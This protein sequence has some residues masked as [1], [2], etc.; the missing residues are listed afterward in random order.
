MIRRRVGFVVKRRFNTRKYTKR[1]MPKCFSS[2]ADWKEWNRLDI[3][4]EQVNTTVCTDCT[5]AFKLRMIEEGKCDHPETRFIFVLDR[6]TGIRHPV[7]YRPKR[8][9][10]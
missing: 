8:R 2:V 4:S 1:N 5:P 10:Q 9:K 3:I 7:G 6:E